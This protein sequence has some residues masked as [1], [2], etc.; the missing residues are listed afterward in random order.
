MVSVNIQTSTVSISKPKS[1]AFEH[2]RASVTYSNLLA[3]EGYRSQRSSACKSSL[4]AAIL[5]E[6]TRGCFHALRL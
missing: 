2:L 3:V 6:Q 5:V 1:V 4:A